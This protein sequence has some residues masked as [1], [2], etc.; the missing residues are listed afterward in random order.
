M[1]E[2]NRSIRDMLNLCDDITSPSHTPMQCL[3]RRIFSLNVQR[4]NMGI[5]DFFLSFEDILAVT[6]NFFFFIYAYI[7]YYCRS[8]TSHLKLCEWEKNNKLYTIRDIVYTCN[9]RKFKQFFSF[10]M[11]VW[12]ITKKK[13]NEKVHSRRVY[14]C[15]IHWLNNK[16]IISRKKKCWMISNIR[17]MISVITTCLNWG[18]PI[19]SCMLSQCQILR[20][21]SKKKVRTNSVLRFVFGALR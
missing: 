10:L 20:K 4:T 18:Q 13:M 17:M 7:C 15:T 14:L 21:T 16:N 9:R 1:K 12:N 6:Q 3:I 19:Y 8:T 5:D 11:I 2:M